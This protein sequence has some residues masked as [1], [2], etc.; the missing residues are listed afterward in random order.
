MNRTWLSKKT[1]EMEF[2]KPPEFSFTPGQ[3]IQFVYGSYERDYS[4]ASGPDD[5]I[6]RICVRKVEKGKFSSTLA[7]AEKDAMF[8]FTGPHGYFTFNAT[9][10]TPVFMATGTG[11]APF[12]SMAKSGVSDFILLHGVCFPEDLYYADLFRS[13]ARLYVPCISGDSRHAAMPQNFFNGRVT[14]YIKA[15]LHHG[16]YEFYLCG[17][18]EMIR[19]VTLQVDDHFSDSHVHTEIFY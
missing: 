3:R 1:F 8:E 10:G 14:D 4:L 9:P 13:A 18:S 2:T 5:S 7:S 6:L 11:I 12:V 15:H 16:S 17:R 19:D